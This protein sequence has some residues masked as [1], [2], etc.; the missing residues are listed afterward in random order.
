MFQF[1]FSHHMA[2]KNTVCSLHMVF[3]S[4]DVLAPRSTVKSDF[5]EVHE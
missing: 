1:L 4:N 5:F 3:M 2:K